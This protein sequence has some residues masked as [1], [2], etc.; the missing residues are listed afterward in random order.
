MT[1]LPKGWEWTT[2]GEIADTSLGKMLDR[3][4]FIGS[5]AVPYLRNINV[6]WG[7]FELDDVLAI[8]VPLE[9]QG[10]FE[11]RPGDLMVCEGGEIGRCAVW[12]GSRSYM[13]FQKA[14]HRVR[15]YPGVDPHF[16]RYLLEYYS[17]TSTLAPYSTGSTIKHLPQQQLRRLPLPLPPH[18]EQ[19][20]I[21]NVLEAQVSRIDAAIKLLDNIPRKSS[22]LELSTLLKL[23]SVHGHSLAELSSLLREP[24][25]NGRSVPTRVGGF[26]VLRLSALS[27]GAIQVA[28]QKGGDWSREQA[29][30]FL[31]KAGDYLISRGNGSLS[32]VGRGGAVWA[33]PGD[34]AFPDTMIRIRPD[35]NHLTLP[36]LALIWNIPMI[37]RQ[38]EKEA[39]TTAGIYKINQSIVGKIQLP[40]PSRDNQSR[41]VQHI[42]SLN[43]KIAAAVGNTMSAQA[44]AT[45][46]RSALLNHAF[47]GRLVPQD[48]ND[49][50]A[51]ILLARIKVERAAQL[52]AKRSQRTPKKPDEQGRL[53]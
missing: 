18:A 17:H 6:Q 8:E 27:F 39:R 20:R 32:L 2:F 7:R 53:L 10:Y 38:I 23:L 42:H 21:V 45:D 40:L 33:D 30:P 15:P 4:K 52:R 13:A 25:A 41:I 28:K 9:Q 1:D 43:P 12:P 50:P 47:A 3:S 49:E 31:V 37:R 46:L 11:V 29:L 35:D 14:L 36:Y 34:V 22:Q 48:P 51:S 5:N 19:R 24:L 16:L 44:R 26:P